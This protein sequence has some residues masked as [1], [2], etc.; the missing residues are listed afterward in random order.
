MSFKKDMIPR[1]ANRKQDSNSICEADGQ[2]VM[3]NL[4]KKVEKV[5]V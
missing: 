4:K 2:P 1:D 5:D 3:T